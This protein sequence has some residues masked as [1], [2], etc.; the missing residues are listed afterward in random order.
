MKKYFTLLTI[1]FAGI[2][3]YFYFSQPKSVHYSER[4]EPIQFLVVHSFSLPVDMMVQR[5]EELG[6]STH[7]L[8]DEKG[9]ITQLVP[10]DKVAWHAGKSYWK[11]LTGL[12]AYS[13][14]IELQNPTFGQTQFSEKQ[15][16]SFQK[17]V[18]KLMKRYNIPPE[19]VV[20]HSDIA[21]TRKA[22]PGKMFPWKKLGLGPKDAEQG[23]IREKLNAI[24][25]DTTNLKA[26]ILAYNRHF[27]PELV[28]TDH[29][30]KHLEENLAQMIRDE[31]H[32]QP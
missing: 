5:L 13:I 14:G 7:Y 2:G 25:Y 27:H 20:G 23:E 31:N 10:D 28:P 19:N 16:Q 4:T 32:S 18:Q 11:G 21:P 30:I 9:K 3:G 24:G 8:I 29:D 26:A 1:L 12:N 6:V 17:L 15:I 22:D